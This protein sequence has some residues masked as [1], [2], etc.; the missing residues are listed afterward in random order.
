ML[1]Y[2]R[3]FLVCILLLTWFF[4]YTALNNGIP[5]AVYKDISVFVT[6]TSWW[7]AF[8]LGG[9][10]LLSF[11]ALHK[12]QLGIGMLIFL[13]AGGLNGFL[14][15]INTPGFPDG[16]EF[17]TT[18]PISILYFAP[19]GVLVGVILMAFVRGNLGKLIGKE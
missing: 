15:G 4:A 6:Y 16:P 18:T 7:W 10:V 5:S 17:V 14:I 11:T 3:T 1:Q 13:V 9:G 8:Y 12:N 19:V 2:M